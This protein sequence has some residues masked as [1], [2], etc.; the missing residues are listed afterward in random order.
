MEERNIF[1]YWTGYSY[2]LIK[3][4][5]SIMY[6]H[7]SEYNFVFLTNQN[8]MNYVKLPEYFDLLCPAH[9][10]DYIRVNVI[11]D[12]GG[13][14]LD[15]DTL[16]MKSLDELFEC[17]EQY[18]GFFISHLNLKQDPNWVMN[19]VFGSKKNTEIM[20][21]WKREMNGI[22]DTKKNTIEWEEIGNSLIS[23]I[24]FK[25]KHNYKIFDGPNTMYPVIWRKCVR[26]F[27]NTSY[28]KYKNIE[29]EYQPLIILVNSVYKALENKTIQEIYNMDN[30][31]KYF[32]DKSFLNLNY[33]DI[34]F[35]EIGTSNFDTLI[36]K[37]TN[38]VGFSVK[39][40]NF[41]LD[42]LP[43]K[44]NVIK[45]NC[46]ITANKTSNNVDIYYIPENIIK[47]NNLADWFIGCNSINSYHPLHIKHNLTNFVEVEK[48]KLLN[49]DEFL[50]QHKIR[51]I[52]FLKIDT[53]GHDVIILNGLFMWIK[54]LPK[55]FYPDK[56]QFESNENTPKTYVNELLK[57]A[58][59][60]GYNIISRGYDTIIELTN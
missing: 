3:I 15:S 6:L 9:Q 38:E 53:E 43:N 32:I 24:L 40:L 41:Y 27:I 44:P 49:I 1:I 26:N 13:I 48:V 50:I 21:D 33:Q 42:E 4:L 10:A 45:V 51:K 54:Y 11:C 7:L 29:K 36:Q 39:P 18:D 25:K 55:S 19:G 20:V 16:I 5:R 12:Y 47:Q 59:D 34:D 60:I 23:K 56:I 58:T 31:L 8:I 14:W 17:I 46:A 28:D 57:T 22:L 35:L 52:K 30:P 37:C 2:K